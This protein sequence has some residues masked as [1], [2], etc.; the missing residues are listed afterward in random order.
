MTSHANYALYAQKL[1]T[2]GYLS[3]IIIT[4]DLI[5]SGGESGSLK[6]RQP[7]LMGKVPI[8]SR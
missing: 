3:D 1:L 2:S 6:P 8:P 7:T 5:K 4:I